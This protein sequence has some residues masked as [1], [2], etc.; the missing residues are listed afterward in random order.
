[1]A[2][3][4]FTEEAIPEGSEICTI[5]GES[6]FVVIYRVGPKTA[7]ISARHKWER[8]RRYIDVD[9]DADTLG[10]LASVFVRA[11]WDLKKQPSRL[12]LHGEPFS[13][14]ESML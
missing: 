13:E 1:M 4:Q 2:R 11:S 6:N 3:K 5:D 9:V 10:Q 8:S 7:R 14:Y 12:T